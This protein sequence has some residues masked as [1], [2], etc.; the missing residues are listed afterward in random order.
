MVVAKQSHMAKSWKAVR[1][2]A[3]A[4]QHGLPGFNDE[5]AERIKSLLYRGRYL[6]TTVDTQARIQIGKIASDLQEIMEKSF[7]VTV[8]RYW[9]TPTLDEDAERS[10]SNRRRHLEI[11]MQMFRFSVSVGRACPRSIPAD[12]YIH[13]MR[14]AGKLK[15]VP[16]QKAF[17]KN[18]IKEGLKRNIDLYRTKRLRDELRLIRECILSSGDRGLKEKHLKRRVH[19]IGCAVISAMDSISSKLAS[20]SEE[21][22]RVGI[23]S[24]DVGSDIEEMLGELKEKRIVVKEQCLTL[25]KAKDR[26]VKVVV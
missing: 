4:N 22:G 14:E 7:W 15:K 5:T 24:P 2:G 10:V 19:S 18:V 12:S 3:I 16:Q 21:I 25:K 23:I 13:I 9:L 6:L 8:E 1:G 20:L 26:V 11:S 17:V